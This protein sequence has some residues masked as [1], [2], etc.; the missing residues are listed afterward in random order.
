MSTILSDC[1]DSQGIDPVSLLPKTIF[2]LSV[3]IGI[4]LLGTVMN[5]FWPGFLGLLTAFT[6]GAFGVLREHV[7]RDGKHLRESV[8]E[9]RDEIKRL[10]AK[11]A[12]K[13]I[14]ADA[15]DTVDY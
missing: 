3:G 4:G 1:I 9:M 15:D 12:R 8:A 13:G 5:S 2:A 6:I 7:R 14:D 11:L 10:K